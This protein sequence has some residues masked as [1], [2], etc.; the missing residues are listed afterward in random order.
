MG[1]FLRITQNL[2][3]LPARGWRAGAVLLAVAMLPLVARAQTGSLTLSAVS[4][5][6]GTQAPLTLTLASP[7]GSEPAAIQWTLT[8][9]AASIASIA[10]APGPAATAAGKT[11]MCAGGSGSYG[12]VLSGLNATQIL[13]GVV[14]TVNVTLASGATGAVPI[15]V[16]NTVAASPSATSLSLS[17]VG[18]AVQASQAAVSSLVCAPGSLAAGGVSTCTVTLTSAV[19][20]ATTVALSSNSAALAIPT[21]VTIPAGSTS[22]AV[23]AVAGAISSNLTAVLTASLNGNFQTATIGLIAGT[24]AAQQTFNNQTLTG[25]YFFRQVSLGTDGTANLTDARSEMGTLVFDGAGHYTFTGQLMVGATAAAP[26]TGTGAYTVDAAGDVSLD[27]PVRAGEKVNARYGPEAIVGSSTESSSNA[28]DIF[29]AILAPTAATSNSSLS[30]SYWVATL[31]FP[32]A[33][34]ANAENGLINLTASGTGLF[35]ATTITGHAAGVSGGLLQTV[36]VSGATYTMAADGSGTANFGGAA[37]LSGSRAFYLS[38]DGNILLGASTATGAHGILIGVKAASSAS[39]ASWSGGFWEAGLRQTAS[40]VTGFA[41]SAVASGTGSVYWTERQK[42]LGAG[43]TDLTEVDSYSL[44]S[45]GSGSAGLA[46]I[47]VGAGGSAFVGSSL[48]Q[49]DSGAYE[50]YF[51]VGMPP[52]VS[53]QS[54]QSLFLNP[55][56][57]QNVGSYAPT[58]NP[59]SPGELIYLYLSG[60]TVNPQT[61]APPYPFSLGGVAVLIN[62]NPAPLYLVSSSELVVLVP[63]ATTGP[64]ASIVVEAGGTASNAV[65]V[66]V[67]A[68]APGVFSQSQNGSG[69]G[70]IRH[71]DY[72][73]VTAASPAHGGEIVQIYLTGLGAIAPPLPDGTGGSANPL[74]NTVVTPTVMVGGQPATVIFSGMSAYP[75]LYQINARLPAI[76][77]GV[78]SLPLVISTSNAYHDQVDIPVTQ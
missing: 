27:S 30:G 15:G 19:S 12:C 18:G 24:G 45:D 3:A 40:A 75:G 58:G 29:V 33:S 67:A 70:A 55:Q 2:P 65:F 23:T 47:A 44:N 53:S 14:A 21:G 13:N 35:A 11:V 7:A 49:A 10:V 31:D 17:G 63:F 52:V 28:Y 9:S 46:Q 51:G 59:I 20:A 26:A 16:T 74:S 56:G 48:N 54:G 42:I 41:G 78:T 8:Y 61:A 43:N 32:G 6:A 37:L 34:F 50:I 38:Q 73:V 76:P 4:G 39:N 62:G 69:A 72:S 77:A 64:T 22:G 1:L 5:S 66:P 71:P 57:V 68:T 60:L 36:P 25:N